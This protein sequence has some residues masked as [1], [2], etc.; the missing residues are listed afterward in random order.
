MPVIP[1]TRAALV[2]VAAFACAS[3]APAAEPAPLAS[4][5]PAASAVAS[6]AP[7][8]RDTAPAWLSVDEAARTV[9]LRLET[10]AKAGAA[11]A[12]INGYRDGGVQIVVPVGWTVQWSWTSTD[13]AATHSLV[14]MAEREKLPERGGRPAF[15]N[16][17]TR[18]L[19]AGL[20]AGQKDE[21]TFVAE[22]AGWYWMLCGVPGHALAGE[23]IGLKV[24]ADAKTAS[25]VVKKG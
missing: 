1:A 23:W 4:A 11:S 15:T 12:T 9:R 22:E 8:A 7:A 14:V 6:A 13:S 16:A 21:T 10:A 5:A 2:V 18:M 24:D 3:T 17:M 20:R 25:V 19:A